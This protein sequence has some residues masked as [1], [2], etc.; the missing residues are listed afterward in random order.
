MSDTIQIEVRRLADKEITTLM[1]EISKVPDITYI[2]KRILQKIDKSY[3]A[4]ETESKQLAGVCSVM[5]VSKKW[6]KVGPLL[7]VE[8]YR[9]QGIG[10]WLINQVLEQH[11]HFNI[12]VGSSN[13]R[14]Q[15]MLEKRGFSMITAWY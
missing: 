12:F 9:G 2:T 13:P 1:E 11:K 3:I 14:V 15:A 8:A 10:G 4:T 5:S 6:V 7:V